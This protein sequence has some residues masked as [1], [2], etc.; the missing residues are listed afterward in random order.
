M[1]RTSVTIHDT[2]RTN[3]PPSS[4]T[5]TKQAIDA[6]TGAGNGID[7]SDFYTC[8]DCKLI[9]ENTTVSEKD[10]TIV[11]G[12]TA[13]CVAAGIGDYTLAVAASTDKVIDQ[14]ES[15]RFKQDADGSLF[16]E[17][18]TGMTGY[19]YAVGTARGIG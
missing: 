6:I 17:F 15:S 13:S 9:V 16:V 14:I 11:A 4:A 8:T 5:I 1:G 7:I 2:S 10:V 19:V 12:P 3:S 18:E